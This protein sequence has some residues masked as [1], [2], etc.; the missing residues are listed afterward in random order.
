MRQNHESH[1]IYFQRLS[2]HCLIVH[3]KE[4]YPWDVPREYVAV[5]IQHVQNHVSCDQNEPLKHFKA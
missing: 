2:V 4:C 3:P 1:I 5:P